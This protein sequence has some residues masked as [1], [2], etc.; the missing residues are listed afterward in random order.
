MH[1]TRHRAGFLV[2]A[3]SGVTSIGLC[4][5]VFVAPSDSA[6]ATDY[7]AACRDQTQSHVVR[8]YYE[9]AE[10]G[11]VPLRCGRWSNESGWGLRKLIAKHGWGTELNAMIAGTLANPESLLHQG[12]ARV[13][14]TVG[15]IFGTPVYRFKVVVDVQPWDA[16]IKGIITAYVKVIS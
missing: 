15:R 6:Y 4:A 5:A 1:A 3:T 11:H 8:R 9:V 14:V 10:L 13:Y 12:T 2:R 7:E 16:G